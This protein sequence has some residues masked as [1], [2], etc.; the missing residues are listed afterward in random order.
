MVQ[1]GGP[2]THSISNA[3]SASTLVNS[4]T[5]RFS[6]TRW[7]LPRMPVRWQPPRVRAAKV[8]SFAARNGRIVIVLI[9]IVSL[10]VRRGDVP[11]W[12]QKSL[13]FQRGRLRSA[14]GPWVNDE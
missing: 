13:E 3:P 9:Q 14:R 10:E 11:V 12:I 2:G 6:V 8:K 4:C 5:G 1:L 7:P